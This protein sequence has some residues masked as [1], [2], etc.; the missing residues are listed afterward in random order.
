MDLAVINPLTLPSLPLANR[1]ALPSCAAVYFVLEGDRIRYIGRAGNLQQRW[2]A[3]HR[4]KQL[5]SETR[6]AWLECSEPELL[7]EIEEA[8]IEQFCPPL[9]GSPAP[10]SK[11]PRIAVYL[12]PEIKQGLEAGA[13]KN[14][15]TV[16]NMAA[17]IIEQWVSDAKQP[18][19]SENLIVKSDDAK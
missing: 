1:S 2:S 4:Y 14:R 7:P 6:I 10:P 8:L 19:D 9:N 13:R 5:N 18:D 17:W 3:H 15:R 11:L 12:P 16:S